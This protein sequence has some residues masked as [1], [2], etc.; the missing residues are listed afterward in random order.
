MFGSRF[1]IHHPAERQKVERFIDSHLSAL[2][3]RR[4]RL[5]KEGVSINDPR[6]KDLKSLINQ[7]LDFRVELLGTK[8][9]L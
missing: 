8:G 1:V 3:A 5:E 9:P 6:L 2:K 7:A 4:E